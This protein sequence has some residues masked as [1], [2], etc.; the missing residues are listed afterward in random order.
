M[1]ATN[2]NLKAFQ[3]AFNRPYGV[4]KTLA[5]NGL[6]KSRAVQ[7][8]PDGF[9]KFD[10]MTRKLVKV[11]PPPRCPKCGST[12]G[13]QTVPND[14]SWWCPNIKCGVH[15]SATLEEIT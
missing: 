8:K 6:P 9:D 10:E 4:R 12:M 7:K 2:E 3:D 1:S 14:G 11:K 5:E 15:L 13:P